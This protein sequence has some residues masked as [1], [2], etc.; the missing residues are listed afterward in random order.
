M[1]S[2][3]AVQQLVSY[4]IE[5]NE[6]QDMQNLQNEAIVSKTVKQ[7]HALQ[8]Q[9]AIAL[10]QQGR[11]AEAEAHYREI[12][13]VQ[14]QQVDALQLLATLATNP[15]QLA[16]LKLKLEQNRLTTPLF[17]TQRYARD[18]E[19]AYAEMYERY[20]ADLPPATQNAFPSNSSGSTLVP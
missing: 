19:A 17:E 3:D 1:S 7:A 2:P 6:H 11:L 13:Q 14:P 8:L 20:H 10:H 18:I 5:M 16:R 12:L 4:T 9:S 15:D